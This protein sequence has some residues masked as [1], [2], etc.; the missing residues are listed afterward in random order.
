MR[1]SHGKSLKW[2]YPASMPTL[3]GTSPNGIDPRE[4][5]VEQHPTDPSRLII[6]MHPP[7]PGPNAGWAMHVLKSDFQNFIQSLPESLLAPR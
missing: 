7:N 6:W 5:T 2:R 4:L 3:L 1:Q